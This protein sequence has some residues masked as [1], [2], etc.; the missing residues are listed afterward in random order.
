MTS[1]QSDALT[2]HAIHTL[3]GVGAG[4]SVTA[5]GAKAGFGVDMVAALVVALVIIPGIGGVTLWRVRNV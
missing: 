2:E 3:L 1:E 5:L 4:A